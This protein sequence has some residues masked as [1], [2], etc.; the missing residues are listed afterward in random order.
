MKLDKM[1]TPPLKA[2]VILFAAQAAFAADGTWLKRDG[3]GTG[4]TD[5]TAWT[6]ANNWTG[7]VVAAASTDYADLGA[8]TNAYIALPDG[9]LELGRFM[10]QSAGRPVLCG[11]GTL[12]LGK[13]LDNFGNV[14]LYTDFTINGGSQ[15]H[16]GGNITLCGD[17]TGV[18]G[19]VT[20]WSSFTARLDLFAKAAGGTRVEALFPSS[21]DLRTQTGA[22]TF[23]APEGCATN[24]VAHW[25]QTAGSRFLARAEGQDAHVL[26]VGTLV[27]GEG[28]PADTFLKR[29]FPDGTIE[30]SNAA[31]TTS[32]ENELTFAALT[33]DTSL[34][35][36]RICNYNGYTTP[37]VLKLQ[38]YRE[39]D[40]LTLSTYYQGLTSKVTGE[41]RK[42]KVTT[43]AGMY[44][45]KLVLKSD[46]DYTDGTLGLYLQLDRA[47]V[48]LQ[49]DMP[50]TDVTVLSGATCA[51]LSVAEGKSVSV[52][53]L[54]SVKAP[55]VKEGA[56]SLTIGVDEGVLAADMASVI[57]EEGTF[58]PVIHG[59]YGELVMRDVTVRAG[60]ALS[61]FDGLRIANLRV[62]KGAIITGTG[63]L[64]VDAFAE[65]SIEDIVI[66]GG[67]IV[68]DP[69]PTGGDLSFTLV[70]GAAE[71]SG[72]G[73]YSL[74]Y[75]HEGATFR[76]RGTNTFD[77]LL[78]GG[79]G[80]GGI[81][82]GGG[83]GGGGVV[84]TQNVSVVEGL[85]AVTAGEGGVGGI[86][87]SGSQ[88]GANGENSLG[89]GLIAYGGGGGAY[90]DAGKSGASGGGAGADYWAAAKTGGKRSPGG[91]AVYGD[92]GFGGGASTNNYRVWS[93]TK[94]GGGGGAGGPGVDATPDKAGDGGIG[95]DCDITG[96]V[97]CYGGGGGGGAGGYSGTM[98][99]GGAG[100]G[101]DSGYTA[102]YPAMVG[103]T[104][105]TDGL[106]GGGGGGASAGDATGAGGKGGRGIVIIRYRASKPVDPYERG[107]GTSDAKVTYRKGYEIHTFA[108]N[109][110][111]TL[112]QDTVVDLL[113]VGG[114]GSGGY[115]GGGGGGGGGVNV[116]TNVFLLAGTYQ[117][118]VGTGGALA[119][120]WGS[121]SGKGSFVYQT[122]S[123]LT[124]LQVKGG[125]GG[126]SR[127]DSDGLGRSGGSG[128]GAG[129]A[130]SAW[131]QKLIKGGKGV[132]GQGHDGGTS[133][134]KGKGL[135]FYTYGAGGGGA[136]EPGVCSDGSVEPK[137]LGIGG[138]GVWCD[139]SG[140]NVCY[141]G[142]GSGGSCDY[143]YG[144]NKY[145][146]AASDGGG[147]RGA[148]IMSPYGT[149]AYPG[150][151]G[152]D[153]LGGGGG[154]GGANADT[155][156]GGYGGKGGD[157]C[158]IIRYPVN[159]IGLLLLVR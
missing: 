146:V 138:C 48:E 86:N 31:T 60:A 97:V 99:L 56:G 35:F 96:T 145:L 13:T 33:T 34:S 91:S 142:G 19:Q 10:G 20:Y 143:Q 57:V 17:L 137:V 23:T 116:L 2:L 63:R 100:G 135:N 45:G 107:T 7:G 15:Y 139:F 12:A 153:G 98:G 144:T 30:L 101:G 157:G 51:R 88:S 80:G 90:A 74:I 124:N 42:L 78:V 40:E 115:G 25:S 134:N 111:F 118:G 79:G 140:R 113:L 14:Y 47:R 131:E 21:H 16:N 36:S 62:E 85:Y 102:T 66:K 73:D 152:K 52:R 127:G 37:T 141:G 148:G 110:T 122:G 55:L 24:T 68:V 105:G 109:G 117:V 121:H 22:L 82:S 93:N 53:Q 43:D 87:V 132:A 49:S 126:G 54:S 29:V 44:P 108:T 61:V 112:A 4:G 75:V 50:S 133:L 81:Y 129:G 94:G 128:G 119:T 1:L 32:A 104:D 159:P 106:G 92:Q 158:V 120:G 46:V 3:V 156:A 39:E 103:A 76:V 84:Y 5:W 89:F 149:G 67:A 9:T 130:Y 41:G 147:G 123:S 71:V 11:D 114:G 58:A 6:D 18:S 136:G 64:T 151:D 26:S 77:V 8:A 150:E 65:G 38:K 27:T 28:I 59:D 155:N 125:G 154:G 70:S 69:E 83:G 72:T 95:R